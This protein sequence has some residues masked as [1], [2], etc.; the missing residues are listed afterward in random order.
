MNN[1]NQT[2][3]VNIDDIRQKNHDNEKFAL[4]VIEALLFSAH[5][6]LSVDEFYTHLPD[7]IH[8]DVMQLLR[9][10]Q[11]HY[12][13]R[14]I[15]IIEINKKW[16]IRT[17]PDLA[18]HLVRDIAQHKKLSKSALETLGIIAYHQ[19]VT[20][21]EIE[22]IRGVAVSK[23]TLDILMEIGWIKLGR[24]RETPGRPVTFVSTDEFLEH[25][26]L[27][28]TKDL[29][30]LRELKEAGFLDSAGRNITDEEMKS[31]LDIQHTDTPPEDAQD[32][33]LT[34]FEFD[35]I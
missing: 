2:H 11:A 9:Q 29:P 3:M 6:P 15:E 5:A 23:G 25:F 27:K 20:R 1:H 14:G 17:A 18:N 12:E 19:P 13:G 33:E 32:K 30:G 16:L 21:T 22:A 10:L 7:N 31:L 28:S 8:C 34:Q 35:N 26:G 24:R 4:R